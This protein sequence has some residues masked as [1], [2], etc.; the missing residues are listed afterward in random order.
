MNFLD[1]YTW[2]ATSFLFG[3]VHNIIRKQ[4]NSTVQKQLSSEQ[5]YRY[6]LV[7]SGTNL[8]SET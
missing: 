5:D 6:Y 8:S 7:S 2:I 1:I 3:N 4:Q